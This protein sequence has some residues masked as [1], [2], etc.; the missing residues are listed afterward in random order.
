M[1][2]WVCRLQLLLVLASVLILRSGYRGTHGRILLSQTRDSTNLQGQVPVFIYPKNRVAWLYP[3]ALGSLF[4]ASYDSQRYGG[5]IRP[6]L[7]TGLSSIRLE[8][9]NLNYMLQN[10]NQLSFGIR[11]FQYPWSLGTGY[12]AASFRILH[13][14]LLLLRAVG[15]PCML[16]RDPLPKKMRSNSL[17]YGYKYAP[18]MCSEYPCALG[19]SVKS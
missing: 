4:V 17:L 13:Y 19:D 10:D 2:G 12:S 16:P 18:R 6:R 9:I 14:N 5:G 7:H 8:F 3:Q 15:G 11:T 1:W